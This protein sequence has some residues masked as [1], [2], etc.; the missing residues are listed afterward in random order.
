MFLSNLWNSAKD[1][2]SN[3]YNTVRDRGSTLLTGSN[4]IGPWNRVDSEY[5]RQHQPVSSSDRAAMEHDLEY[6]RIARQRDSGQI[7]ADEARRRIRD[8]D[9]RVMDEFWNGWQEH[10]WGSTLGL[11][12]IGGKM[13]LEDKIGIDPN[14]FVRP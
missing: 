13:I 11:L 12:G 4:Y 7:S 5:R 2:V 1:L 6:E 9:K 10:P 3:V 14:L 8:S